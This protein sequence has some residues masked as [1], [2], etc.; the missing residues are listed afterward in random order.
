MES[1]GVSSMKIGAS[2][3]GV[4]LVFSC[5]HSYSA[6]SPLRSLSAGSEVSVEIRRVTSCTDDI[7][8]E[9][10]ATGRWKSTAALRAKFKAKAV[11]PM[12]GRAARMMRSDFCQPWV[13]RSSSV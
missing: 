13:M 12:L 8:K 3:K 10:N 4:T 9:K 6:K 5:C 7:S 1:C 11:L 2:V